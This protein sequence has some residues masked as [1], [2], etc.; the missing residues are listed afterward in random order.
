MHTVQ[1]INSIQAPATV[2]EITKFIRQGNGNL[3]RPVS[4]DVF[5]VNITG[6]SVKRQVEL[7]NG[8][9]FTARLRDLPSGVYQIEE[10]GKEDFVVTYRVNGG[11]ESSRAS[12]DLK[13]T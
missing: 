13:R 3:M 2:L 7:N 10:V 11:A 6:E 8:N 9:S 12:V 5:L 4:G 1:I